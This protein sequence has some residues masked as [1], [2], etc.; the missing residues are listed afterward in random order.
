M[1]QKTTM[2][3]VG[4]AAIAL[5][6][7]GSA[8]AFDAW[9]GNGGLNGGCGYCEPI[10][11]DFPGSPN[12]GEL[13]EP[14]TNGGSYNFGSGGWVGDWPSMDNGGGPGDP[15][16]GDLPPG[17]NGGSY[18]FGE[19][20]DIGYPEKGNDGWPGMPPMGDLPEPPE[21]GGSYNFGNFGKWSNFGYVCDAQCQEHS[22]PV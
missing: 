20:S 11:N 19:G 13:P 16:F 2:I 14:P 15:N 22:D 17:P 18:N 8:L 1:K 6:T 9:P 5:V 3:L 10:W 7:G 21:N 12:F 4:A